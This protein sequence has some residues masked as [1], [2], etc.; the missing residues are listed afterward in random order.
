[1]AG[2]KTGYLVN[3]IT[4]SNWGGVPQTVVGVW[5]EKVH[6]KKSCLR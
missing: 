3:A 5:S 6:Q 2:N 4:R 1:M